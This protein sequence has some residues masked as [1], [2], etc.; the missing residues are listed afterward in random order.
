MVTC[1]SFTYIGKKITNSK[2]YFS[3]NENPPLKNEGGSFFR[4]SNIFVSEGVLCPLLY[5][6]VATRSCL[7]KS[8]WRLRSLLHIAPRHRGAGNFAFLINTVRTFPIQTNF[9]KLAQLSRLVKQLR[10]GDV[11]SVKRLA[12]AV[13]RYF[14]T[15]KARFF[16]LFNFSY[17]YISN[18]LICLYLFCFFLR[19]GIYPFS[20]RA[21]N[22]ASVQ[23]G[24]NVL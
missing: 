15:Q 23:F 9:S 17:R 1:S 2:I 8:V 13:V 21:C 6:C 12:L 19:C 16:L 24:L 7:Y 22:S 10:R 11:P 14:I 5:S 4:A 20:K 18:R 3:G